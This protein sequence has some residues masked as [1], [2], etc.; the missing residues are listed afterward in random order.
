MLKP[1][2]KTDPL[3]GMT[4]FDTGNGKQ[5]SS[6]FLTF[7]VMTEDSLGWIIKA[8]PGLYVARDLAAQGQ[9]LLSDRVNDILRSIGT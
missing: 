9:K 3:G 1:S 4:R 8:K 2:H 5:R 6:A 7:R